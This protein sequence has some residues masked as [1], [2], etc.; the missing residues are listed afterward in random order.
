MTTLLFLCLAKC[1]SIENA[2]Q[3]MPY[4]KK[5]VACLLHSDEYN[6]KLSN[7]E[8]FYASF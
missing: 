3:K 4:L 6:C 1:E 5:Y 2:S 8:G 7:A